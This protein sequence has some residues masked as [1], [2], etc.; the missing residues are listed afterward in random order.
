MYKGKI[1]ILENQLL[2]KSFAWEQMMDGLTVTPWYTVRYSPSS[3]YAR[4]VEKGAIH[5]VA[6]W[7]TPVRSLERGD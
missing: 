6:P 7:W 3:K 1:Y 5:R 4:V 2:S